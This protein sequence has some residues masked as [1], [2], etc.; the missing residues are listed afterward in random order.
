[1]NNLLTDSDIY[2]IKNII[3]TYGSN[4]LEFRI[5]TFQEHFFKSQIEKNIYDKILNNSNLFQANKINLTKELVCKDLDNNQKIIKY[6]NNK[7]SKIYYRKK[8][9]IQIIDFQIFESRIAL[10]NEIE[11]ANSNSNYNNCFRFKDRISKFS[12]DGN[13]RYDFTKVYLLHIKNSNID[14]IDD[15]LK[16][17]KYN[18]EFEIEFIGKDLKIDYIYKI[19]KFILQ[20][21]L[22]NYKHILKEIQNNLSNNVKEYYIIKKNP[23]YMIQFKKLTNPVITV[24]RDNISNILEEKFAITEK[25]DGENNFFYINELGVFLINDRSL[26]KKIDIIVN[27][28]SLYGTLLNGEYIHYLDCFL[29]FDCYIYK[30]K[31]ISQ[32]NLKY[33]YKCMQNC[34]KG[35]INSTNFRFFTKKYY[36]EKNIFETCNSIYKKKYNYKIDGII[37]TPIYGT[38]RSTTYKWKPL[39]E[40]TTDFLVK[41]VPNKNDLF[42]LYVTIKKD[43]RKKYKLKIDNDHDLFFP[44]FNKNAYFTPVKFQYP[45]ESSKTYITK[46]KNLKDNTVVE[47]YYKNKWIPTRV[48]VDKTELYEKSIKMGK[49]FGP[50]AYIVAYDNWKNLH[51]NPITL[52]MITGKTNINISRYFAGKRRKDSL[53]TEMNFFHSGIVKDMLYEE[54]ISKCKKNNN[55]LELSGGRGGDIKKWIK[56]KIKYLTIVDLDNEALKQAKSRVDSSPYKINATYIQADCN[57]NIIPKLSKFSYDAVNM[58]FAIHYMLK[59]KITLKN[60]FNNVNNKLKKNGYFIFTAL[61]GELVFELL[62]N[63]SIQFNESYNFMKNNKKIFAI[64]RLYKQNTFEELG[65]EISVFVETLGDHC[66]EFLVNY[67]YILNYFAFRNYKLIKSD[68]FRNILN[69]WEGKSNMSEA[70]INFSSLYRYMVLQKI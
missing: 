48:R 32:Q 16:N 14:N 1:M 55:I 54:Y 63:N 23:A 57:E 19:F 38:I 8:N 25:A 10:S 12:V 40:L 3:K 35:I 61:D 24:S 2:N 58:H 20:Y 29:T 49:F 41:K 42:Y 59:N 31:D 67:D 17:S 60:I 50:N 39:N 5:G 52:D 43:D 62:S 37:F 30:K 28:K 6:E 26:I 45:G 21:N 65:Q 47:F 56:Y 33:R 44:M 7:Q 64:K 13:W 69:K 36:F 53:I 34:E 9:R 18:Y 22:N 68:Y 15:I 27:D 46:N 70:E 4:E 11:Y 66:G 51:N